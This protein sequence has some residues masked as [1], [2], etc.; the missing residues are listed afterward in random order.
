MDMEIDEGE[1]EVSEGSDEANPEIGEQR[2]STD[3]APLIQRQ[4]VLSKT[5]IRQSEE[6][7]PEIGDVIIGGRSPSPFS[8]TMGAHST[9]WVAHIDAVRRTLVSGPLSQGVEWMLA[10]AKEEL[11]SSPLL[12][13]K[14]QLDDQHKDKLKE[15]QAHLKGL[16][17]S[18]EATPECKPQKRIQDL[19]YLINSYLTFVNYLPM[20]TVKGGDPHTHGEGS[21]RGDLNLF[22]YAQS[23]LM[24]KVDYE[25]KKKD[26]ETFPQEDKDFDDWV[27]ICNEQFAELGDTGFQSMVKKGMENEFKE[28]DKDKL[29]QELR[30]K[31]W[32]MFAIETPDVFASELAL[33][34]KLEIWDCAL[35]NF[36]RIIRVAYPYSYDFTE[37]HKV[38]N[39]KIGL[40]HAIDNAKYSMNDNI[41]DGIYKELTN[42]PV[43]EEAEFRD[44]H[45]GVAESDLVQGGVGFQA[46]LFL[47]KDDTNGDVDL[48][49][50]LE[51]TGRTKSPFSATMGAHSTAWV[52]HLDAVRRLLIKK[53]IP[54]A[55]RALQARAQKA[56]KDPGLELSGQISEK[57]QLYLIGAFNILE[58]YNKEKVESVLKESVLAQTSLL[59][60][61]IFDYLSFVNY[62][63]L[64]TVEVAL[65]GARRE[66]DHRNF[67]L[68]YEEY[69]DQALQGVD[70]TKKQDILQ[71]HLYGLFDKTAPEGF[72]PSLGESEYIDFSKY[73][74]IP[75]NDEHPLY[76][77]I[78]GEPSKM[79]KSDAIELGKTVAD[80]RFFET[81]IEAYPRATKDSGI[82]GFA[83]SGFA[84]SGFAGSERVSS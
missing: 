5:C 23:H 1:S 77:F 53:T 26:G 40:R 46:T 11:E 45:S 54:Q 9:A 39:Q 83:G 43:N 76:D 24:Y 6:A 72:P 60:K 28:E 81:I 74:E 68:N 78:K 84:G 75:F 33:E 10:L 8:G 61:Y 34:K 64:S 52:A 79:E 66:G 12:A 19:K 35:R 20:S 22:E 13:L 58:G 50:A 7:D 42:N 38:E 44:D 27:K 16:V 67:L 32:H 69:G 57:H 48:I 73:L 17:D 2:S 21:A 56:M 63:P 41:L 55:L 51:M 36:L 62:L 65:P 37:M 30:K 71:E 82:T 14:G 4:V 80:D 15:A 59:E 49:G 70:S 47:E 25:Q 18:M 31:L 3:A 29:K